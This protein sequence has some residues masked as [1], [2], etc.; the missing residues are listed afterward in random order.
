MSAWRREIILATLLVLFALL[1]SAAIGHF[2]IMLYGLTV[3]ALLRQLY[4]IQRLETWLKSGAT[5]RYPASQGIWE[6]IY[7]HIY[8]IKKRDKKRKKRLSKMVDEFRKSTAA[9]PDAAV[10]LGP[11]DEIEWSNKAARETLGLQKSDKGQRVLNLIR[12]PDFIEYLKNKDYSGSV[13]LPSPV[14]DQIILECRIVAYGAGLRLLLAHDVTQLKKMERM[15]KDF[16]ANVS[17]ELRTPLTVLKGYLE[18]LSDMETAPSPLLR[19]SLPHMLG[20]TERMQH[21]VDD[22]LLLA[23]L[24]TQQKKIHCVDIAALLQQICRDGQALEGHAESRIELILETQAGLF[25][26]EQ[27]LRSAFSNLLINALKYSPPDTSVR[28]RWYRDD[29]SLRLDVEDQG[30]GIPEEEIPRITE[31]FYRVESMRG[32]T[33]G[34]GLGL[35]IVKHVLVRH[36]AKLQVFSEVGKGSCFRCIFP[37]KIAC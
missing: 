31:R 16:V 26:D 7:Y 23:R 21:L 8:R 10:V 9:L 25:G 17:H 30:V 5:G 18:T 3:F 32:K 33:H 11:Y 6:E 2:F 28:V 1:L 20:Q 34:T 36:E 29:V 24:E 14:N 4:E 19:S 15:R 13:T 12:Y 35:A 27:E 22:L 37:G